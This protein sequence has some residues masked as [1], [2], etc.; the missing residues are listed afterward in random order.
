MTIS[1]SDLV[2]IDTCIWVGFFNR[3]Q[4]NERRAVDPLLDDDRAAITG[5]I[6]AEVLQGFRRDEQADWAASSLKGLHDLEPTSDDWRVAANLGRHLVAN[7]N[8]L[9]LTDL[10]IAAI[11]MRNDC[12]V[13]TTDPHFDLIVGLKRFPLA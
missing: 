5:M 7:G 4:S 12:S 8:R 10:A 1:R 6:L 2:L 13:L 9:P 11:A 3:N